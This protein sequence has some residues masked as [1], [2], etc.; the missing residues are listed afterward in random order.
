ML[1]EKAGLYKGGNIKLGNMSVWS[2][3]KLYGDDI[4]TLPD[5]GEQVKGSCGKYCTACKGSCYVAKAAK[6]Y[7]STVICHGRNT[8]AM[9]TDLKA[10]FDRMDRQIAAARKKPD[11]IRINQSGELESPEE[12]ESWINLSAKYP[13]IKFYVYSKAFDIITPVLEKLQTIPENFTIL[14][15]VWHEYGLKEYKQFEKYTCV[16]AFAY[17]DFTFD[18]PAAG[19]NT[20][21]KCYAYNGK[22]LN[23]EITCERCGKCFSRRAADKVILCDSH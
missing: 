19:L 20:T 3:S 14:F 13:A 4:F 1:H 22:K 12:L 15:S 8:I 23:H 18:Y 11:I 6:R 7:P 9:R 5:T 17:N 10:L 21:T 16:K 2:F